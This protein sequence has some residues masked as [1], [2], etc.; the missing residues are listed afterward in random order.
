METAIVPTARGMEM[1]YKIGA[2]VRIEAYA[3]Q[4]F[5]SNW[6]LLTGKVVRRERNDPLSADWYAVLFDD[7]TRPLMVHTSRLMPFNAR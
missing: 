4:N 5:E 6:T 2:K 7:G 1:T 3:G